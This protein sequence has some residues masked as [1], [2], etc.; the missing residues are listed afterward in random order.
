MFSKCPRLSMSLDWN[1]PFFQWYQCR[2]L[3]GFSVAMPVA[4]GALL[5]SRSFYH[6]VYIS[7]RA[8]LYCPL[9]IYFQVPSLVPR[10]PSR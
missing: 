9:F 3:T 10:F 7:F 6:R 2:I 4:L 8:Y 1:P 5:V